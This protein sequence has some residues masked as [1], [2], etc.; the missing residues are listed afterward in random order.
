M[1]CLKSEM[2]G[3]SS[4]THEMDDILGNDEEYESLSTH[5]LL[6]VLWREEKGAP[7]RAVVVLASRCQGDVSLTETI[8]SWIESQDP[9]VSARM[10]GPSASHLGMAA[11]LAKGD[12]TARQVALRLLDNWPE[13]DRN[14]LVDFLRG[15][16]LLV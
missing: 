16:G 10:F 8:A 3:D 1:A 14:K 15:I 11:L 6:K 9:M 2:E 7:A 12:V 4:V 13:M 5:H